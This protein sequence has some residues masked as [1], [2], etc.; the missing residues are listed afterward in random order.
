[1]GGRGI[2]HGNLTKVTPSGG[3]NQCISDITF[4]F[5]FFV[6]RSRRKN[7]KKLPRF[8]SSTYR[9]YYHLIEKKKKK[10]RQTTFNHDGLFFFLLLFSFGM[11]GLRIIA[12]INLG[13]ISSTIFYFKM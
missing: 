11:I 1:M 5:P 10:K 9:V 4:A 8:F 12:L 6:L 2:V 13:P 7:V 3:W